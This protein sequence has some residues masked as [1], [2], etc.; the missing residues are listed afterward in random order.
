VFS[1]D[2]LPFV[3][4]GTCQDST[5]FSALTTTICWCPPSVSI[6]TCSCYL[7]ASG[8]STVTVNC[9]SQGLGDAAM[10]SVLLS[11]S[12]TSPIDTLLLDDNNLTKVPSSSSRRVSRIGII[13]TSFTSLMTKFPLLNHVGLSS[14]AITSILKGDLTLPAPLKLLNLT[15]NQISRIAVESFPCENNV[16][17]IGLN[18]KH[19]VF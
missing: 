8:S 16:H 4:G 14:N 9:A 6:A 7:T 19:S 2:Y 3:S 15:S 10:A 12:S 18:D 13:R 17:I 1:P 5:A 11:I